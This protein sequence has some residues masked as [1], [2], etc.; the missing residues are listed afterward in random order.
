MNLYRIGVDPD[1]RRV[2]CKRG[3]PKLY[4]VAERGVRRSATWEPIRV[5]TG[6][7]GEPSD[8]PYFMADVLVM[9]DRGIEVL[10]DVLAP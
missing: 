3:D 1:V 4:A 9:T 2:D 10:G 5:I 7:P 8:L 6:G